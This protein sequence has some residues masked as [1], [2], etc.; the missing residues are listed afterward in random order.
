MKKRIIGMLMAS[1]MLCSALAGCGSGTDNA[2][3]TPAANDAA[4][5]AQ[6]DPA[7]PAEP[8]A[9]AAPAADLPQE[10][11]VWCWDPAFNMA[12]MEA[13]VAVYQKDHPDFKLNIVETPWEDVQ[14]KLTIAATANT[15]ENL[16]D[17]FLM[18]DTA[19]QK[20]VISYP[21]AFTDLTGTGIPFDQFSAGKVGFSTVDGKNYGVPFDNGAVIACYRTDFL[22]QAG[23]TIDDFTDISWSE[24]IEKGKV[25]LEKTG[26]PLLSCVGGQS[27]VILMM[28]QSAG[29]NLFDAQGQP[30]ILD[31]PI[32]EEVMTT[33]QELVTS[34]VM[35]EVN[36][37]DQYIGTLNSETVAGTING[38]WIMASIQAATDQSG[39]WAMTNMPKLDNAATATNY[40][41]QGGSS[42][43]ISSNCQNVE[44]ATDFFAK[45]FGGST[46]FYDNILPLG[47]LSCWL[48]A[49]DSLNY[50][51]TNAFFSDQPAYTMILDFA[52]KIPPVTTGVYFYEARDAVA[53]AIRNIIGG[54]DIA[55]EL[56]GAQDTVIFLMQQ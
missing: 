56:Q 24:Y 8:A 3:S 26:K 40:A 11:T 27:D 4:P 34:G 2:A 46:E 47:A 30:T 6:A 50:E 20:N 32:L 42:W 36:D 15:M 19:F 22:E 54:Q 51:Q 45:T 9:D 48:P 53:T 25:V 1:V 13:A 29:G 33:Y 41:N 28:L 55:T 39:K 37:W 31:N 18:Q 16:P 52:G 5:A 7:A 10:L 12:S 43:A 21:E 38:C 17:I 44:L 35:V 14:T 23:Y 49:A